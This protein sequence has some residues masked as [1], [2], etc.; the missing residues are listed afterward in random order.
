MIQRNFVM[1]MFSAMNLSFPHS[2]D[3]SA[4]IGHDS[5]SSD[6]VDAKHFPGTIAQCLFAAGLSPGDL[7]GPRYWFENSAIPSFVEYFERVA[8]PQSSKSKAFSG[9]TIHCLEILSA[10]LG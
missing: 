3:G 10:D 6:Q 1:D 7:V 8:R 2:E 4:A 9:R 5:C